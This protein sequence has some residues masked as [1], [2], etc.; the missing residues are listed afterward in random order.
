MSLP[1]VDAILDEVAT[2]ATVLDVGCVQH[3]AE[4][5]KNEQWL[6]GRLREHAR[7]VIGIDYLKS[8]VETLREKGYDVHYADAQSF[9]LDRTFDTITAGEVIEHLPNPGSFL[10]RAH[11]HLEPKGS[12]VLTTPNPWT[13]H[14]FRGALTGN[15]YANPEHTC[16]FDERTLTQLLERTGFTVE[17]VGYL[18]PGTDG[19]ISRNN[20]N[21]ISLTALWYRLGFDLLGSTTLLVVATPA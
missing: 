5:E 13:F 16:W 20:P 6:H 12:L 14:R 17:K 21:L 10:E 18:E 15:V 8:E 19:V 1:R 9:S 11:E 2:D 3:S 7:D 4:K